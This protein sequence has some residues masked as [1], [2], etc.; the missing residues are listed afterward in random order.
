M[1]SK[2]WAKPVRPGDSFFEPTWYQTLTP[3][4]GVEWSSWKMTLSPLGRKNCEYLIGGS[5]GPPPFGVEAAADFAPPFAL[6]FCASAG[7]AG[8]QSSVTSTAVSRRFQIMFAPPR[9]IKAWRAQEGETLPERTSA[10]LCG[11]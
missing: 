7:S 8:A 2:R 6:P 11:R 5:A 10:E 3:T 4:T 1:C 9:V